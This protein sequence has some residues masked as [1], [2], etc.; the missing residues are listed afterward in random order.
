MLPEESR[1]MLLILQ[2]IPGIQ[3]TAALEL[4]VELG[5]DNLQAFATADR[6]A[7][8]VGLCQQKMKSRPVEKLKTRPLDG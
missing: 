4:I 2:T 5:G 1:E 3:E 7:S 6:L 8:W